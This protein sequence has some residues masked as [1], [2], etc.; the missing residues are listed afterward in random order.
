MGQANLSRLLAV[1]CSQVSA[2]AQDV[3]MAGSAAM[4]VCT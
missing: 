3:P 1:I 4:Q 2:T